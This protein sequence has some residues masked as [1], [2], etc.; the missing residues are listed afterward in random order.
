MIEVGR[1]DSPVPPQGTERDLFPPAVSGF[2]GNRATARVE[3]EVNVEGIG[4]RE[5]HWRLR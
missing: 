5:E 3:M 1:W 2:H 4:F